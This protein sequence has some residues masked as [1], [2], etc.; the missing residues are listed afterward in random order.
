M[1]W[2]HVRKANVDP[3]FRQM[4]EELGLKVVPA[5]FTQEIG[6][7]VYQNNEGEMWTVRNLREHMK[8]RPREQNDIQERRERW[9]PAME[10]TIT[11][12]VALELALSLYSWRGRA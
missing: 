3:F 2:I 8:P 1:R 7:V 6:V 10:V 5:Y 4:L 12:F 11:I 9:N